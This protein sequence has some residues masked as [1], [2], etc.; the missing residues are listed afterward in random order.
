MNKKFLTIFP[1]LMGFLLLPSKVRAD[2]P[3]LTV[4]SFND[5]YILLT[6]DFDTQLAALDSGLQSQI[7]LNISR[8]DML[9]P[10]LAF[11]SNEIVDLQQRVTYLEPIVS[12]FDPSEIDS[13][14]QLIIDQASTINNLSAQIAEL[15][16]RVA[17]LDG[18]QPSYDPIYG[19][20]NGEE[21]IDTFGYS[22]LYISVL[23]NDVTGLDVE[24]SDDQINWTW[25]HELG[26]GPD[27]YQPAYSMPV[28]GRYYRVINN[29][30]LDRV[31]T[32]YLE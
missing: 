15:S 18:E 22:N 7:D 32:W 16:E 8:L 28:Q 24:Y 13:L 23:G 12:T 19:D 2:S 29:G 10:S 14:E 25:Q 9:E 27:G 21:P 5:A 11:Q 1:I 31:I 4:D 26:D 3:F 20:F 6:N 30:D 17:A